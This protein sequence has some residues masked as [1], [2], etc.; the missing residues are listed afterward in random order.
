MDFPKKIPITDPDATE[1]AFTK[2]DM[3]I[4]SPPFKVY[5]IILEVALLLLLF[6]VG[7][8][9]TVAGF[10]ENGTDFLKWRLSTHR[11]ETEDELFVILKTLLENH[12]IKSKQIRSVVIASVVPSVNYIFQRFSEKYLQARYFWLEATDGLDIKWNVK[13]PSEIGA[14]RVANVL[15]ASLTCDDAIILDAGT[16]ITI[17][18]LKNKSYEG[19]AILPGLM[20]AAYSLFEKTAKLPQVDLHVPVNCVGK[21]TPDNIRIGIVKGTAYALNG[22][23]SDVKKYFNMN[24]KI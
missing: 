9:H 2:T 10:T 21:D 18:V 13:N 24:P 22:L 19:G 4:P 6:D 14:D 7:N 15:G 11:F 12:D 23:V 5:Y 16:A 1:I 3:C 20:T 17:D 8:T